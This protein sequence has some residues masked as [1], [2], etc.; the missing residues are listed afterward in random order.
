MENKMVK[1]ETM[2]KVETKA[3]TVI[4]AANILR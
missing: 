2:G 1:A 4:V 3:E